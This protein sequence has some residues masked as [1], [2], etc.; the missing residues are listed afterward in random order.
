MTYGNERRMWTLQ[1]YMD[2]YE[3][4][5]GELDEL[6]EFC[7]EDVGFVEYIEQL[8]DENERLDIS[9]RV[10]SAVNR[11]WY[12][13]ARRY[14]PKEEVKKNERGIDDSVDYVKQAESQIEQLQA[15]IERLKGTCMCMD[16][17]KVIKTVEQSKHNEECERIDLKKQTNKS[18]Y[19]DITEL[20]AA[21]KKWGMI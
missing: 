19:G 7:P 12:D 6:D 3:Q 13:L 1:E 14:A 17:G 8:Q 16:C 18:C 9:W 11:S 5:Q 15:E 21:L 20:Q 4:L 10:L 2:K